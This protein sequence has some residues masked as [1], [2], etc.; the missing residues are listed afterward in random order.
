MARPDANARTSATASRCSAAGRW[1]QRRRGPPSA[2]HAPR[3]N[4][5]YVV[6][7]RIG[8]DAPARARTGQLLPG[9]RSPVQ[10]RRPWPQEPQRVPVAD[11]LLEAIARDRVEDTDS[12]GEEPSQQAVAR[13]QRRFRS[14]CRRG[15][16]PR[17]PGGRRER[18]RRRPR[19]RARF[20]DPRARSGRHR[21]TRGAEPRQAVRSASPPSIVRASGAGRGG[22]PIEVGRDKPERDERAQPQ[23]VG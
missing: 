20:S 19:R 21:P 2:S 15:A 3:L 11:G 14:A 10:A 7:S 18:A 6:A 22:P 16:A 13:G 9:R 12:V 4:V 5:K 23:A 1:Q 17:P 8:R